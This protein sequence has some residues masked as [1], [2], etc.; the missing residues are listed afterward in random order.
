[1]PSGYLVRNPP[2]QCFC[3]HANLVHIAVAVQA[4]PAASGIVLGS[5]AGG[6]LGAATYY[7]RTTWFNAAG[8]TTAST[9]QSLAV[10]A[11]R[12][13][14]VSVPLTA[15]AVT[16]L[17]IYVSTTTNTETLQV[18]IPLNAAILPRFDGTAQNW[19]LP[20]SGLIGGAALPGTNTATTAGCLQCADG[21]AFAPEL[22]IFPTPQVLNSGR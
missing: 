17:G 3:G 12:L 18:T 8:Q 5:V 16:S 22:G 2:N 21:H 15:P 14:T 20:T 7:V 6:A 9:E 13:L 4:P 19:T 1:M 10:G 11:N